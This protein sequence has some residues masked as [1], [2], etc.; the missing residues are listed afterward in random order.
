MVGLIT[1]SNLKTARKTNTAKPAKS[2]VKFICYPEAHKFSTAATRWGCKHEVHLDK[3][4]AYYHQAQSQMFIC[5]VEYCDF[6]ISLHREFFQTKSFGKNAL[7]VS[8][9]LFSKCILPEIV[10]K[11]Y[12]CPECEAQASPSSS[13]LS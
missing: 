3:S 13:T 8:S 1:A 2:L 5:G 12:T 10:G 4:R 11:C 6:V 9:E 7:S